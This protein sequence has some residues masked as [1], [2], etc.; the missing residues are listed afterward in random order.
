MFVS[1]L[2][3]RFAGV[4][5]TEAH[6]KATAIALGGW[7]GHAV[8]NLGLVASASE[9]ERDA[10]FAAIAA[11]E[12]FE[13]RWKRNLAT[14]RDPSEQNPEDYWLGPVSYFWPGE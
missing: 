12:G 2:R 10:I 8:K 14:D 3:E 6:P 9:H 4:P 1:R 7:E 11:R 5:V 13:G